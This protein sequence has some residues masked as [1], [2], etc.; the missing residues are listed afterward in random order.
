MQQRQSTQLPQQQSIPFIRAAGPVRTA[1]FGQD[2]GTVA[3]S[4]TPILKEVHGS[5]F[6][7]W[8]DLE[9]QLVS[10]G[11]AST[12]SVALAE[13][14]PWSV[15]SSIT[16]DDGGPQSV[17]IDGYG[18][19]LLNKYGGYGNRGDELST[20]THVY[21]G[22]STGTGTG[23]GSGTIRVPV[24][25]AINN[26]DYWGLMGNQDKSTKYNLRTNIA[27]S[28]S[29]YATVPTNLPTYTSTK[30]QRYVPVPGAQNSRGVAQERIPPHYGIVHYLMKTQ[31][32]ETPVGGQTIDHWLHNLNNAVRLFI[33]VFR[34][35]TG[36]T[37]RATAESNMPTLITFKIG[38]DPI[39][40][41]DTNERRRIMWERYRVDAPAGVLVYDALQDFGPLAG[42]ELG[43]RYLYMGDIADAEF[44][45]TYPSG[46]GSSA[47]NSLTLYT[48]SLLIPP[49][50][51]IY[52]NEGV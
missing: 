1:N 6:L 37:P 16:L 33:L 48:D 43:D 14:A 24:P 23:A 41:E 52:A 10:T 39:W 50:V 32:G 31:F 36:A 44:A 49:N 34:S 29:I 2:T 35:G 13:D 17:N 15:Y 18:A 28:T 30:R 3:T 42:Y 19:Y 12:N 45:I 22:I 8:L 47:S 25:V 26:R 4:E 20:D 51:D 38:T 11:N 7:L 27:A 5:G 21:N 9:A 40:S 46:F